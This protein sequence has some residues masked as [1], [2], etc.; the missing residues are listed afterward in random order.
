MC[1]H[2][3][4]ELI[5]DGRME[6]TDNKA[7]QAADPYSRIVAEIRKGT[8]RPGDRLIETELAAKYGVSR[9]PVREAVHRLEA[10]GLVTHVPRGGLVVRQLDYAEITELYAMRAVLEGTAARF[11]ARSVSDV[12]MVELATIN[13]EMRDADQIGAAYEANAQF[14]RVVL[15]AARNRFLIR[16]VEAVQKT[17][18]IL[19]RSTLAEDTRFE[20]AVAEHD[21]ILQALRARDEDGAE[22]LMREHIEAALQVR[23]RQ[24]RREV[25]E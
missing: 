16:A 10:D 7:R 18:L 2:S 23:L 8:I 9:T 11:A 22:R 6:H 4:T 25:M 17:L 13:D 3:D 15:N 19:G 24:Y 14:H 5:A 21:A 12:E 1:I 20:Q